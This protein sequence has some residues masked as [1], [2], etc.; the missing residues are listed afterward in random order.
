MLGLCHLS[1]LRS[2]DHH[3]V[4]GSDRPLFTTIRMVKW[5]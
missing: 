5:H 2:S 4:T 3:T 1:C